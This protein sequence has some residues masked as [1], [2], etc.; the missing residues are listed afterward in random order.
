MDKS[1]RELLRRTG[2]IAAGGGIATLAGC[3]GQRSSGETETTDDPLRLAFQAPAETTDVNTWVGAQEFASDQGISVEIDVFE[4]VDLAVQSVL[5]GEAD[6]AR[7]SVTAVASVI[8]AGRPFEFIIT[9]IRSTDYVLT[10]QPGIESL[11]DIV[12]QD[13]AIGMSAP[14]GLDAV[15]VAA[16][17]F[18]A[19]VIDSVDE[20]NYQ[21]I[22]YSGARREAILSGGIDVSPQHYAQWLDMREQ[23]SDLNNILRFGETLDNWIQEVFMIPTDVLEARRAD[24][25]SFVAAQ[26]QGYRA[27]YD[28]YDR[29]EQAIREYVPG[30]GP[31]SNILSPTYDFL[32][33]IGIWPQNGDLQ[34]QNVDYMLDLS[35]RVGLT[36]ERIPTDDPLN[37]G[38]LEDAIASVGDDG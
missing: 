31:D 6:I 12:E 36:D 19:G 16:V 24:V 3:S 17:M 25:V 1:R 23:N 35:E 15:Q 34:Q 7:G 14:T 4:G 26:L 37:R 32:T 13:A 20:L 22:G 38:P 21:R 18:Q 11:A 9:P 10:T 2:A 27:L 30:G 28:G 8:E 5:S 33:D 29:Y